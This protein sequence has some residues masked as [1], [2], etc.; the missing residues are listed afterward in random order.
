MRSWPPSWRP[1][2]LVT[3]HPPKY[4]DQK[5]ERKKGLQPQ[6]DNGPHQPEQVVPGG[7]QYRAQQI[8]SPASS[9]NFALVRSRPSGARSRAS[10]P[11]RSSP[12]A[13]VLLFPVCDAPE[14]RVPTGLL[15]GFF[16]SHCFESFLILSAVCSIIA[17]TRAIYPPT[18]ATFRESGAG[19]GRCSAM[20]GE[21]SSKL[22][23][24]HPELPPRHPC[25]AP[26][27]PMTAPRSLAF[28]RVD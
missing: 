1:G 6:A 13:R 8:H 9:A 2:N 5:P 20:F 11:D 27:S 10:P 28:A 12:G 7:P 14:G 21:C 18:R 3:N 17:P 19:Q 24:R 16:I 23:R 15:G 26:L 22:E 25:L 4:S